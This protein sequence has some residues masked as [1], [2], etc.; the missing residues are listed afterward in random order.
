[1]LGGLFKLL[2]LKG[3]C[4]WWRS[5][6]PTTY[7]WPVAWRPSHAG[8]NMYEMLHYSSYMYCICYTASRD[9]KFG[10]GG[11]TTEMWAIQTPETCE[12]FACIHHTTYTWNFMNGCRAHSTLVVGRIRW[13]LHSTHEWLAGGFAWWVGRH[14]RARGRLGRRLFVSLASFLLGGQGYAKTT[15]SGRREIYM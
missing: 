12:V 14:R 5:I 15:P 9:Y 8:I 11:K 7:G 4:A 10:K 3:A 6:L 13:V 1:M 2:K